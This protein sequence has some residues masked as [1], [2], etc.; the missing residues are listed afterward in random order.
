MEKNTI[1][2]REFNSKLAKI[3]VGLLAASVIPSDAIGKQ[4]RSFK[5]TYIDAHHHLDRE[6]LTS[7]DKFT[8]A[9]M[10]D[11]MDRNSVSQ[12]VVL[13]LIQYPE[14]NIPEYSVQ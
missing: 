13:A 6:F 4:N 1:S 9:P 8:L 2:R 10:I 3:G 12:T 11:W 14:M 5:G 7:K